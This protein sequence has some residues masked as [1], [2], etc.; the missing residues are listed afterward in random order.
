M[1]YSGLLDF[2]DGVTLI[3]YWHINC[4]WKIFPIYCG[5]LNYSHWS[6]DKILTHYLS[7]FMENVLIYYRVSNFFEN[8][9]GTL[10]DCNWTRTHNH[11]VRKGTLNHLAK[12]QVRV[13]LW[14]TDVLH[15]CNRLL[16]SIFDELKEC[17]YVLVERKCTNLLQCLEFF[18][19]M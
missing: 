4:Q 14:R 19:E 11:L 12:L 3:K 9:K 15:H 1:L 17:N 8:I 13:S 2:F 7:S 18:S 16:N 6:F 10:N 5:V